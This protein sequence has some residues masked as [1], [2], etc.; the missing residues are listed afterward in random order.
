MQPIVATI[1]P[2]KPARRLP[3]KVA[4]F[5]AIGPGVISAMVTR[6]VNSLMVS[7][8]C[9]DTTWLRINGMAA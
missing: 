7:Q 3:T 5:T 2:V 9:S 1:A 8:P 4:A 6:S